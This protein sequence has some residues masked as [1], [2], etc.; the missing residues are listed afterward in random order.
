MIGYFINEKNDMNC[1]I[2]Q[3]LELH[4]VPLYRPYSME[5]HL[6]D[7]IFNSLAGLGIILLEG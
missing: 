1:L 6:A 4:Q 3:I 7:G 5:A 2:S